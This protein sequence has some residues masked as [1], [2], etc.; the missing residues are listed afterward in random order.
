MSIWPTPAAS[1]PVH[2]VRA[3]PATSTTADAILLNARLSH[4]K[5]VTSEATLLTSPQKSDQTPIRSPVPRLD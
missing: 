4:T 3:M 1:P 2:T 5:V